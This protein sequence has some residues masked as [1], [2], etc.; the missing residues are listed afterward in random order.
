[1]TPYEARSA[2]AECRRHCHQTQPELC[3]WFFRGQGEHGGSAVSVV[4]SVGRFSS[5]LPLGAAAGAWDVT[6]LNCKLLPANNL[7]VKWFLRE[8]YAVWSSEV[9]DSS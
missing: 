9:R 8:R 3:V 1:M 5:V 6:T 2:E 7:H 4:G